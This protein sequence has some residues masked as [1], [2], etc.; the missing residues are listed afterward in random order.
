LPQIH[1]LHTYV[2]RTL[3]IIL[4]TKNTELLPPRQWMG[5][6]WMSLRLSCAIYYWFD[7]LIQPGIV[8]LVNKFDH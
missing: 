5:Y 8:V 2:G 1:M 7:R 3:K 4:D 6:Y